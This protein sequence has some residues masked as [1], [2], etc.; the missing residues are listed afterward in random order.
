[1]VNDRRISCLVS[2]ACSL[3]ASSL[4]ASSALAQITTGTI[5]GSVKDGQGGV[6]PG[7]LVSLVNA[8]R[9]ST[10]DATTNAQGDFVFP[11]LTPGTYTLRVALEGFKT[12]ERPGIVVSPGDRIL[13]PALTIEVGSLKDTV[14]VTAE[15]PVLQASS[16]E[17]S[18]TIS[19]ES[20]ANLPLA[21]RNFATLASLAPGVSGTSRTGDRSSTGGGN[22]NFM[23]DGVS[24]M[25]TGSNRLLTAVNVESIAEVKVLVSNY[26]AEYGR[27]SGLQI[28]AVTKSGTNRFRGSVY[29]VERNSDWNANSKENILNGDPK[30]VSKQREWGYSIGGPIGRAGGNNKLFFFYAQE[31]Q[32]RTGG[33]NVQRYRVPTALERAGDF[34]RTT[35]N[36]GTPYSLIRDVATA[37]PCT[38]SDTRGCF[39]D[40]GVLGRIPPSRLYGPGVNILKMFPLPNLDAPGEDYNY[41]IVRPSESLLAYQPAIRLDYQPFQK[42][43][44]TVKYTSWRQR[45]QTINGSIPGFND[46]RMQNPVVNM[47]SASI[48][49]NLSPTMFL[50]GTW[51]WS[52]ND[53]AGCALQGVPNFCTGALPMNDAANRFNAGLGGVPFL[54]PDA[55]VLNPSYYAYDVMKDVQ[56]PIWDGARI[57]LPPGFDWGNRID[58]DP[59]NIPFPGFL[60][61]NRTRDLSVSLTKI[62]GPHTIKTGFYNTHS[63]KAQQR[64]GWNG[65]INFSND[66]NNPLDSTFGF[67]NAALGTFSSYNQASA[68]VEGNFVYDNIEGYVQDNW[69]VNPRLTL[70]YGVRLVHQQPQ[71]DELGQAS[72]FLPEEWSSAAAPLLY[73]AGCANGVYPCSGTNR[74]AMNPR[75]GQFLGPNS[76]LAIGTIVPATGNTINGLFLSGHGITETTYNWPTLGVSPRFGMA[77]DLTGRQQIILRGGA[78]LFYDRPSGNSIYSQVQ[79]PPVYSSVTVRNGQLQTLGSGGLTTDGAPALNVFEYESKMPASW[80]WNAGVQ[81]LLPWSTALDV[82]YVGQHGYDIIEG[83]NLNA[84]DFGAAFLP[85]NQD[86]SLAANPTPGARAVSQDQM[87]SF[88]GYGSVTQ[89]WSRGWIT[90]H[91]LQLSLTRRFSNGFSFGFND[92]IMLSSEGSTAARLQHNPDGSYS[93]RADQADADALL[94]RTIDRR[95]SMKAHFVWDLPD[96]TATGASRRALALVVNDWQVSGIW[97]GLTGSPYTV[98]F[99][100][101]NGG[102]SVNLTGSQDYGARVR[103]VG[104]PGRGCSDDPHRQFNTAAFQGPLSNSVGLESGNDYLRSCFSSVL[105]LSIARNIRI[106]GGRQVQLRVDAFNAPNSAIIDGRASTINLS[107]P[108]DP[109]TATNLPFDAN[110]NLIESRSRPRGAGFG[111]ANGYQAP[112]S[113]QV[114]V[115]FSF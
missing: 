32:P 34:S 53:Q 60:N 61:V 44:G 85:E 101:Q 14:T 75:T 16:G 110:G 91:S 39:Q 84:V 36:N 89:Q 74:Q 115:R 100:Y 64:G 50:E 113:I 105:D 43:R 80:Q 20:V 57:Q 77:Y 106:G 5:A 86:A 95:H 26:Q 78:G 30:G 81:M 23:M 82:E 94:G 25:D 93:L 2:V 47:V 96:L 83:V 38:A 56:P 108:N 3:V 48:N 27:S 19:T 9:G 4:L 102:S 104:D 10:T 98:G 111:V 51:G 35:D 24:T 55:N 107:N 49:Y 58:N 103:L 41:E 67:S 66:N 28:T 45:K 31:F 21:D 29:D 88:R 79:N 13:V 76:T 72:N 68:Y 112:R 90:N 52:G 37:L 92:T 69:K 15:T 70:D 11:N 22:S 54:F 42:L 1:M 18:F 114:Q 87:R 109:V 65:T 40:G 62:W 12:V 73:V 46:T 33:N 71:F 97:T 6:V 7:A 63:W 17:R 59:P 8:E 99:S